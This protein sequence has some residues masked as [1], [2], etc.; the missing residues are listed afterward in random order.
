MNDLYMEADTQPAI[1]F[2]ET[3]CIQVMGSHLHNRGGA[4]NEHGRFISDWS[5]KYSPGSRVNPMATKFHEGMMMS[6]GTAERRAHAVARD[7]FEAS[8]RWQRFS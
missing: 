3:W 7:A 8:R 4:G 2:W 1:V 6:T 5:I